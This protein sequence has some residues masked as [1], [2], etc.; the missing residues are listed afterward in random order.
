MS[1]FMVRRMDAPQRPDFYALHCPPGARD[2]CNCVAWWTPTWDGWDARTAEDNRRLRDA[3]F[4]RGEFD[5][6]LLYAA[7]R[8]CGWCQVGPR[9][10]LEK[11]RAQYELAPD[12]DAW[13]VSCFLIAPDLR[14]RGGAR[15]LLGEALRDLRARG[16]RRIEAFPRRGEDLPGDEVW[17]GPEPLFARAGFELVRDHPRLPIYALELGG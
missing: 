10:R 2:C 1:D 17:T 14:G 12:P 11:L 13:A 8:A 16:V 3:L 4:E 15:A 6:Y 7:G 5:G 9:D